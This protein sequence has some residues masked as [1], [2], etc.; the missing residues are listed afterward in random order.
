M[1]QNKIILP[2]T[3]QTKVDVT[4]NT[5]KLFRIPE[6]CY[7]GRGKKGCKEW[8]K[9]GLCSHTL[10]KEGRYKKRRLEKYN[11]YKASVLAEAKKVGFELPNYGFAL[12]FY[13]PIPKR[14][15]IED[16]KAMHGQPH[17]RKPDIDNL[18]KAIYDSLTFHDER[19]SQLSGLGKFWVD[20]KTGTKRTD[21]I[22]P[23]WIE[24]LINQPVYN[25]FDVTF[26]DQS[27]ILSLKQTVDYKNRVKKG[28]VREYVSDGKHSKKEKNL[29]QK[30][31]R[32][33]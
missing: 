12:Y 27:K 33:K 24:I 29:F 20:T 23:G 3:P 32:I 1:E 4:Q 8:K 15:S 5:F 28:E 11:D 22:G 17:M 19:I 9:T 31:D 6:T 21:P 16:R 7:K 18:E 2:I 13:I 25:P 14:W 10:S 26:I 30:E